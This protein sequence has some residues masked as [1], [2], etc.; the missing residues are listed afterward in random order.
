MF[1]ILTDSSGMFWDFF[2]LTTLMEWHS[3]S[4]TLIIIIMV[5]LGKRNTQTVKIMTSSFIPAQCN[6]LILLF[7]KFLATGVASCSPF[8]WWKCTFLNTERKHTRKCSK[9]CSWPWGY[10]GHYTP[11]HESVAQNKQHTKNV[12]MFY[13][14]VDGNRAISWPL[15]SPISLGI[16]LFWT[17]IFPWS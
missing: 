4:I 5:H 6:N 14:Y 12:K 3:K 2:V 15:S 10:S 17:M 9:A 7:N 11:W 13:L 16:T 1:S 8:Q